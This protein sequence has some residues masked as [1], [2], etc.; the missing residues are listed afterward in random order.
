MEEGE[1]TSLG[2]HRCSK[3]Q[4]CFIIS[5]RRLQWC[6]TAGVQG[7]LTLPMLF[8]FFLAF[9]QSN[10]NFDRTSRT[11]PWTVDRLVLMSFCKALNDLTNLT[12]FIQ[13]LI[14]AL[15]WIFWVVPTPLPSAFGPS[16]P[17]APPV[18]T[19]FPLG[20]NI[21]AASSTSLCLFTL[22]PQITL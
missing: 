6:A 12:L 13:I 1:A 21:R 16:A 3:M 20:H 19:I 14:Y 18:N 5:T 7:C 8:F 4:I 17:G 9:R 10:K 22:S 11:H 2:F 15:S